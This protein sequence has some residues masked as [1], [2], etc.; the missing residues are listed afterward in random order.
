VFRLGVIARHSD[1]LDFRSRYRGNGFYELN[2][3][4]QI[5]TPFIHLGLLHFYY[6]T[7][8]FRAGVGAEIPFELTLRED[9]LVRKQY[10]SARELQARSVV[11][12]EHPLR[13]TSGLEINHSAY[14]QILGQISIGLELGLQLRYI[15]QHGEQHIQPTFFDGSN[16]E[17][18]SVE[19]SIH[20]QYQRFYTTPV[21]RLGVQ[22]SW[23]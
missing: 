20:Q 8:K 21:F 2:Y 13:F 7:E 4:Y 11:P 22:Y 17:L 15:F 18:L 16:N 12:R 10:N 5:I 23:D 14:Y 19:Y 1:R 6:T 3:S 9:E